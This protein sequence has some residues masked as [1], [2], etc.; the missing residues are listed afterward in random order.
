MTAARVLIVHNR[1]Q[2]SGGE[3]AVVDAEAALLETHGHPVALFLRDNDAIATRPALGVAIEALWSARAARELT[4]LATT[5]QPDVVHVHNTF[6]LVSPSV[7]YAARRHGAV[8]VQTIHNFRLICP[9]AMLLRD[10][11]PCELCVGR[12]PLPA[13]RFGCYRASRS[14][15]AVAAATIMLH[16]SLGTYRRTVD[17]YIA[18]TEFSRDKLVQGGLPAER[19]AV[20]PNFVDLPEVPDPSLHRSGG[21]FVG[22]LAREKGIAVLAEAAQ[23]GAWSGVDVVGVGD[24]EARVAGHPHLRWV[25]K[26]GAAEVLARMREASYL[27]LPSIWYE[28]FPRTIV[29]AFG[30]G[31]PVIASRI[32]G[33]PSIV[34]NG[35]TG[36]LFEPGNPHDLVRAVA[37]AEANPEAMAKMGRRA[38]LEFERKYSSGTNYRTLVGVYDSARTAAA[39]SEAIA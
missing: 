23:L 1:Y 2:Q 7:L 15:S 6:P 18:L 5:F 36:L 8:V 37:W 30:S 29:E 3:D 12:L 22:R 25:G 21:L 20:K 14:Q 27:L 13:I 35:L 17:R 9:Q 39:P 24:E 10:G 26:A 28:V 38:R 16:R 34:E 32:G 33:I 19:I 4:E 11:R 31:L